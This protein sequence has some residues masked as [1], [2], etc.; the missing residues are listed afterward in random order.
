MVTH[1]GALNGYHWATVSPQM[2]LGRAEI[3]DRRKQDE[4]EGRDEELVRTGDDGMP[5][6]DPCWVRV[7]IEHDPRDGGHKR[8]VANAKQ[9]YEFGVVGLCLRAGRRT[10]RVRIGYW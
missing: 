5:R 7:R 10:E 1:Q 2:R 6:I 3:E 9:S 4:A 8:L